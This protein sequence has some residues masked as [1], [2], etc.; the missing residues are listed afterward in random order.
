MKKITLFHL[1]IFE[2]KSILEP[3]IRLA[4]STFDH[5]HPKIFNHLLIC[6]KLYQHAKNQLIPSVHTFRVQK[7]DWAHPFLTLPKAKNFRSTFN[8]CEFVSTCKKWGSFI[9]LFWR[10]SW[11]KNL[12]I[13]MAENTL[14]YI[15]G[16][17]SF[18]NRGF[19]QELSK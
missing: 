16:T 14:A 6:V 11:F 1:L 10:N 7:L 19:V 17:R 4:T 15:S 3:V 13:W 5:A 18:L 12:A 2:V 8:F 9:S